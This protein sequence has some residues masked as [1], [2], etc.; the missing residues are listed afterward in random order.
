MKLK[1]Q[2]INVE[3]IQGITSSVW[4]E[5]LKLSCW[6]AE[7]G[8]RFRIL[9]QREILKHGP[10]FADSFRAFLLHVLNGFHYDFHGGGGFSAKFRL[11][12][13]AHSFK[14]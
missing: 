5:I 10:N 7:F 9:L 8:P 14:M 1:H 3:R 2:I 11:G 12:G 4:G 6:S 13:A